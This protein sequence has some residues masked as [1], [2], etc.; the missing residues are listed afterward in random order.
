M[1]ALNT[2]ALIAPVV[3]VGYVNAGTVEYLYQEANQEFFFLELNPRLQVSSLAIMTQSILD[4][5]C[6]LDAC[7]DIACGDADDHTREPPGRSA[8]GD[9]LR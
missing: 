8:P 7:H 3:Q 2:S 1:R 9:G 4:C 6:Y 5:E